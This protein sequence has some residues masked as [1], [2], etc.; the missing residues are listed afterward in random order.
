MKFNNF[1]LDVIDRM[2]SE[3][4]LRNISDKLEVKL[5]KWGATDKYYSKIYGLA[6]SLNN[7]IATVVA[8]KIKT[9]LKHR[10]HGWYLPN[11]D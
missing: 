10:E 6:N 3:K 4:A 11:D 2:F 9:G 7:S 8:S 1:G 5:K